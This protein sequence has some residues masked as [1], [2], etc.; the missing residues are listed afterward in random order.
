MLED[1]VERVGRSSPRGSVF[2][3]QRSR[4]TT[5]K[6]PCRSS[7][8]ESMVVSKL[9]R[10][11]REE[12]I[13]RARRPP[14]GSASADTQTSRDGPFGRPEEGGPCELRRW[15]RTAKADAKAASK[16]RAN[17]KRRK[18]KA[19]LRRASDEAPAGEKATTAKRRSVKKP[20]AKTAAAAKQHRPR[21]GGEPAE[22]VR[23]APNRSRRSARRAA[24]GADPGGK[25]SGAHARYVRTSARKRAGLRDTLRASRCR[26]HALSRFHP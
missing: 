6:K 16:R 3:G 15:R 10:S 23:R 4:C 26:R 13:P 17:A 20:T 9:G 22:P 8:S 12:S 5:G 19:T 24:P 11:S 2:F 7:L 14:G 21:A 25:C 18:H 1:V